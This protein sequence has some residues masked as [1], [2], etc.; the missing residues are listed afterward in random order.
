MNGIN[1]KSQVIETAPLTANTIYRLDRKTAAFTTPDFSNDGD[2]PVDGVMGISFQNN[3][4]GIMY[5]WYGELPIDTQVPSTFTDH[6]HQIAAGETYEPR[7]H[8]F[9]LAYCLFASPAAGHIHHQ[10][11]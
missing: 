11:H 3:T 8:R 4:N 10:Y 9:G 6:A 7:Q 2:I 1:S 5:L